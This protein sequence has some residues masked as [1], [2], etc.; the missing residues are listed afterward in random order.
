MD[1]E[2]VKAIA[3]WPIPENHNVQRFL[4]FANFYRK[5]VRNFSTV[6]APLHELTSPK[7]R[8]VIPSRQGF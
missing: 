1:P 8:F 6:A 5:F 7:N 4:G 2:K 3:E